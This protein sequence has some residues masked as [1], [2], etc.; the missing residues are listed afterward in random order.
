MSAPVK[1]SAIIEGMEFHGDESHKK[2]RRRM[3]PVA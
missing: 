1:L 3:V 2:Y